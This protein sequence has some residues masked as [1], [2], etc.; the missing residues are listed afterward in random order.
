MKFKQGDLV[1]VKLNGREARVLD[2]LKEVPD[3]GKPRLLN[4]LHYIH[5]EDKWSVCFLGDDKLE[6]IP[7]LFK[8]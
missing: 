2:H 7:E 5:D 1:K 6:L 8:D 3:W 4:V